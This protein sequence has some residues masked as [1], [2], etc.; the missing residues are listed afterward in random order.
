MIIP[1]GFN[2][3]VLENQDKSFAKQF[4]G[5]MQIYGFIFANLEFIVYFDIF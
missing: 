5:S 4:R 2:F 3:N 1:E